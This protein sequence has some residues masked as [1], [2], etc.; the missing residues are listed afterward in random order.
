M[1]FLTIV[2]IP[3]HDKVHRGA[4]LGVAFE[5]LYFTKNCC[6]KSR[7]WALVEKKKCILTNG[8]LEIELMYL[9]YVF[10]CN[11]IIASTTYTNY[12]FHFHF[13]F[14]MRKSSNL[15][16]SIA[17]NS[18]IAS[19]KQGQEHNNLS[20]NPDKTNRKTKKKLKGAHERSKGLQ[21]VKTQNPNAKLPQ[22]E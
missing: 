15:F 10:Q 13:H 7:G 6:T 3:I 8:M 5:F 2:I 1:D 4:T 16:V 20:H 17:C 18:T 19:S 11:V 21:Y 14:P 9:Y 22:Q 12:K